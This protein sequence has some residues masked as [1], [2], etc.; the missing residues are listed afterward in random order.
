[1][2]DYFYTLAEELNALLRPGEVYTCLLEGE[3]S[4]FVRLNRSR[5]RQAGHVTQRVV[6]IDLIEGRRHATGSCNIGG[7]LEQDRAVLAELVATLREQRANLEEDPYLLY[8]GEVHNTE[9]VRESA[10]PQGGS[11]AREIA[12]AAQGLDLVGLWAGGLLYRAFANSLGQR[13]WYQTANFNFDWSCYLAGD[14]A[15]KSNY[16]GFD[17]DAET[18]AGRMDR[19][20]RQLEVMGRSPKTI[21]P[22]RYRV[23][24]AP[25]AL[26]EI[27][28]MMSWGGFG[29]K[30]HRTRQTPLLKMIVEGKT[31]HPSVSL[32]E[33]QAGG[34]APPF[35]DS[36]FIKP[37]RVTLIE[38]G[39]YEDHLVN[40][41]SS[42]EYG[43]PVN[44]EGE[45]PQSLRM[46]TG[47]LAEADV[48]AQL[49]TGVYINNL[50][51]CNFSDRNDCRI[52]GMTR[53]ASFWVQNGKIQAPLNV[54]RFDESVY[55]ML[56]ERL[57]GLTRQDEFIFDSDTYHQRSTGSVRLPGALID[58]FT[59]TL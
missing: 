42:A 25:S 13:N 23:Y 4:D 27:L 14:K 16:A 45:Y 30:S 43:V 10:L 32:C 29:L 58:D 15:V 2:R 38:N 48:P 1:M 57:I 53:F 19:V 50:W 18:L 54:M 33:D 52:T 9:D 28:Q 44:A 17:W 55:R 21:R 8:A 3:D 31:L 20:R 39:A 59:F 51:Y 6:S 35:T 22:G 36:G 47:A 46:A 24:L 56:G 7:N 37:A 49:E 26:Q 41:R 12:A 11:A 40:T 5:V 34:L